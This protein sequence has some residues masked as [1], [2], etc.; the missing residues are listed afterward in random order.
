MPFLRQPGGIAKT[1]LEGAESCSSFLLHQSD[2]FFAGATDMSRQRD[3]GVVG[4]P[5]HHAVKQ[6]VNGQPLASLKE[7][8]GWAGGRSRFHGNRD[9]VVKFRPFQHDQCG[10][11]FRRACG[12]HRQVFIVLPEYFAAAH[13]QQD[14]RVSRQFQFRRAGGRCA[15]AAYQVKTQANSIVRKLGNFST[16]LIFMGIQIYF[17]LCTD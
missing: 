5:E 6:L 14:A 12:W 16:P 2:E 15:R 9:H 3:G 7:L 10:D 17:Q 4:G 1:G 11:N 13:L 8:G